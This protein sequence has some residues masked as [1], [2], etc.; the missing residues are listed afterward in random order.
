MNQ[1]IPAVSLNLHVQRKGFGSHHL[2]VPQVFVLGASFDKNEGTLSIRVVNEV[3][4]IFVTCFH[5]LR[6]KRVP[7]SDTLIQ[8]YL[9]ELISLAYQS[10]ISI[11]FS[12]QISFSRLISH[13]NHQPDS[14]PRYIASLMASYLALQLLA[15]AYG[16]WR[17]MLLLSLEQSHK[18]KVQISS[19]CFQVLVLYCFAL[20]TLDFV[21]C[22]KLKAHTK[23]VRKKQI[24]LITLGYLCKK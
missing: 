10:W 1:F 22:Y 23:C 21:V 9:L 14:W 5:D 17:L 11:F 24:Y 7:K 20:Q 12:Q 16:L 2:V 8:S 6:L 13:R 18:M 3:T 15:E 4:G 19:L